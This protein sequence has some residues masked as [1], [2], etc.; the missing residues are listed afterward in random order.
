VR[1]RLRQAGVQWARAPLIVRGLAASAKARVMPR[2]ARVGWVLA[3]ASAK[4]PA[5][6]APVLPEPNSPPHRMARRRLRWMWLPRKHAP[7][8][9]A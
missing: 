4:G 5:G 6:F 3:T 9:P 8:R 7:G 1:A 2:A